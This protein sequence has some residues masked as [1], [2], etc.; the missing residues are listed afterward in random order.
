MTVGRKE[1]LNHVGLDVRLPA[2]AA[3]AVSRSH[4][5]FCHHRGRVTVEDLGSRNGTVIRAGQSP[6]TPLEPGRPHELQ[7]HETVALPSGI[8]IELSGRSIPMAYPEQV[9]DQV[10]TDERATRMLSSSS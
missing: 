9:S 6:G 3:S 1:A 7:Q 5:F 10:E 2:G 8:T 4:A